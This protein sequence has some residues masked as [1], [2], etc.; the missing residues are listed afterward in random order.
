MIRDFEHSSFRI[1]A[2]KDIKA[3]D[4]LLHVLHVV[5]YGSVEG[6]PSE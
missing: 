4:E 5:E 3:G 1:I 2:T 6:S